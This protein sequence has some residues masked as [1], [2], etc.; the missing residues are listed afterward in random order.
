M[1]SEIEQWQ[2]PL[3][4][5]PDPGDRATLIGRLIQDLGHEDDHYELHPLEGAE[6]LFTDRST[7]KI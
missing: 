7:S 6:S 3:G 2:I 5:R 4:Y 1:W